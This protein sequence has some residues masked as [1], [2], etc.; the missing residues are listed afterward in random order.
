M[1]IMSGGLFGL[2]T[3]ERRLLEPLPAGVTVTRLV[4][5]LDQLDRMRGEKFL[6]MEA[7][8][9]TIP[10]IARYQVDVTLISVAIQATALRART[11]WIRSATVRFPT[12][13]HLPLQVWLDEH[14]KKGRGI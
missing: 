14:L 9:T 11:A 12:R 4:N 5:R 7:P 2:T 6:K 8:E 1:T 10:D 3:S 13:V